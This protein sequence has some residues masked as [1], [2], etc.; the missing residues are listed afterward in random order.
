MLE[1]TTKLHI[2]IDDFK[3][4]VLALFRDIEVPE[5]DGIRKELNTT[6]SRGK[7]LYEEPILAIS[8]LIPLFA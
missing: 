6:K 8:L 5:L 1:F 7:L 4:W 3:G 2:Y